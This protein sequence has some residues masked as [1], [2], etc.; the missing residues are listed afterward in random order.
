MSSADV[1]EES[2]TGKIYQDRIDSRGKRVRVY[3]DPRAA[4]SS[5]AEASPNRPDSRTPRS[6]RDSVYGSASIEGSTSQVHSGRAK[7]RIRDP[8][9]QDDTKETP[10]E[11]NPSQP[12]MQDAPRGVVGEPTSSEYRESYDSRRQSSKEYY[13]QDGYGTGTAGYHQDHAP[14]R[15]QN[16]AA[17]SPA[18]IDSLNR[19]VGAL[20]ITGDPN[21]VWD[22]FQQRPPLDEFKQPDRHIKG[23]EGHSGRLD[24]SYTRRLDDYKRF[25]KV[26]RVFS[27][28]WTGPLGG[29]ATNVNPTFVSVVSYGEQVYTTIRRFVVVRKGDR[30]VTCL[31]VTSYHG[32]GYRKKDIHLGDHG[33]I[34]SKNPPVRV[35]GMLSKALKVNLS[36]LSRG[37]PPHLQDP[38]LVNYSKPY[39]VE[40]NVK[41]KDIGVL[42][43]YSEKVLL[44]YFDK[45]FNG[46]ESDLSGADTT[47]RAT[48]AAPDDLVGVGVAMY[49][50]PARP[51]GYGPA[52]SF[53]VFSNTPAASE[54]PPRSG[55]GEAYS[56]QGGYTVPYPSDIRYQ[57]PSFTY[58]SNPAYQYPA[59]PG[60]HYG[61]SANPSYSSAEYSAQYA[62]G[63]S[64]PDTVSYPE[65]RA[66][67]GSTYGSGDQSY[68][69]QQP[70]PPVSSYDIPGGVAD[71]TY[72]QG[73]YAVS[74]SDPARR[75]RDDED[76]QLPSLN[77]AQEAKRRG[78]KSDRK[79]KR[80]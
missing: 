46:R 16:T 37:A 61:T 4:T 33:F 51:S 55:Y 68:Y 62:V 10:C 67:S 40:T 22:S 24:P 56:G 49:L 71:Q 50:P 66:T 1:Y 11:K 20:Q 54:Y 26:G 57:Q 64:A 78:S 73:Q 15:T 70:Q 34:C 19:G 12:Y 5:R 77:D 53:S 65:K 27:T 9:R 3:K 36:K 14:A 79:H 35:E 63:F 48:P 41:V 17:A 28:L 2:G 6:R 25:F 43:A 80:R 47:P 75:S 7:S 69:A 58:G 39:T 42:D 30:S 13:P 59:N 44:H 21:Y 8:T 76:I 72:S 32:K 60:P 29:N 23:A 38:S 74:R 45:I 31:P 52:T 18:A